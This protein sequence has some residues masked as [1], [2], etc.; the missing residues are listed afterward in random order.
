MHRMLRPL[1]A[2]G[3]RSLV[4]HPRQMAPTLLLPCQHHPVFT[5]AYLG[6]EGNQR[7]QKLRRLLVN[8]PQRFQQ[9]I[10]ETFQETGISSIF[11][12]VFYFS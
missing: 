4:V 3:K 7:R 6:M 11:K 2:L 10:Q 9:R 5:D 12:V 1:V 8:N